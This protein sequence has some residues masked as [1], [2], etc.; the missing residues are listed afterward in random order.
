MRCGDS[1]CQ[2][3]ASQSVATS[4][5]RP[6]CLRT[7]NASERTRPTSG[8]YSATCVQATTSNEASGCASWVASPTVNE[9]RFGG[10]RRSHKAKVARNIDADNSAIA[11]NSGSYAF[12]QEAGPAAHIEHAFA[13]RNDKPPEGFCPL[14]DHVV[15]QVKAFQ[16]PR[17]GFGEFEPTH[18][19]LEI[20]SRRTSK[21]QKRRR[22]ERRKVRNGSKR[23]CSAI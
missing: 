1:E 22:V 9:S 12:A 5:T 2:T 21:P 19:C 4:T 20:Q 23:N 16:P 6:P 17:G 13:A 10:L 8:T 15:C 3:S 14:R 7:R 18:D 11:A